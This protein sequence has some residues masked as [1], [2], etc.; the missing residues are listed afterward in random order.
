MNQNLVKVNK[1]KLD[2]LIDFRYTTSN[3][4][5]NEKVYKSNECF[6]HKDCI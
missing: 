1:K 2:V 6:I 3:N 5:T 4:F